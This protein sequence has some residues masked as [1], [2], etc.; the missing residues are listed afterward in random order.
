MRPFFSGE[1]TS[2]K[3]L[4]LFCS[5][6]CHLSKKN[7]AFMYLSKTT[8]IIYVS[9]HS[10]HSGCIQGFIWW[11]E[12]FTPPWNCGYQFVKIS[13]VQWFPLNSYSSNLSVLFLQ[14]LQGHYFSLSLDLEGWC[15]IPLK[16]R[17]L[18]VFILVKCLSV[19]PFVDAVSY[20]KM[21]QKRYSE[22][23]KF[24]NVCGSAYPM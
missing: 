22:G 5:R 11:A 12:A 17:Q 1:S 8:Y 14:C 4:L 21:H 13:I 9:L 16:Y 7:K 23:L 20:L 18:E 2:G 15:H 6:Y 10:S 19:L 3:A 24:L